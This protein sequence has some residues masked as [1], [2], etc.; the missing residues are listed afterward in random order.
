[1][2]IKNSSN[3]PFLLMI[4]SSYDSV[5]CSEGPP[6]TPFTLTLPVTYGNSR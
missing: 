5:I 3:V 4:P 2:K 6:H 1:M